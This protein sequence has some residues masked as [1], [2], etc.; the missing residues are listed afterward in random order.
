MLTNDSLI[1]IFA[2]NIV[3]IAS[4]INIPFFFFKRHECKFKRLIV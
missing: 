1:Y 3:I 2:D 4:S